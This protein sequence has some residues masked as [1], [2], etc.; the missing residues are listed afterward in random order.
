MVH[1]A[2]ISW[3]LFYT[4]SKRKYIR[5]HQ[6]LTSQLVQKC[7]NR[8]REKG[9]DEENRSVSCFFRFAA[10]LDQQSKDVFEAL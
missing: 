2:I 6:L 8:Q 10:L 9:Q 7:P 4:K 5:P 3:S 1:L